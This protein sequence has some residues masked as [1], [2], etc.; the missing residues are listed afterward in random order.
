MKKK[1]K[2]LLLSVVLLSLTLGA[3][4]KA[5]PEATA[6][7][8]DAQ[9]VFTAA[10]LTANAQFTELAANTSTSEPSATP[11]LTPTATITTTT[12]T[13]AAT[14]T[15]TYPTGDS[16]LIDRVEFV[17]DINVPD[18]TVFAPNQPF[19][20]TWQLKNIGTSTWTPAYT[21]IFHGGEQMDSNPS[22]PLDKIVKPGETLDLSV[23]LIS[24]IIPGQHSSYWILRNSFG[25]NFGV[26]SNADQP[27]Y[28]IIN[29]ASNGTVMVSPTLSIPTASMTP[30]TPLP[31]GSYIK[32]VTLAVETPQYSGTCPAQMRVVATVNM[33]VKSTI[34]LELKVIVDTSGVSMQ[35]PDPYVKELDIGES[36][37]GWKMGF[38]DSWSGRMF[39]QIT[40]PENVVSDP[41]EVTIQ[42]T[43]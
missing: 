12:S 43:Q 18:Y 19:I 39:V 22:V 33:N 9:A 41:V 13:P 2:N 4:K 30:G 21:V 29:V 16:S 25:K 3:C 36:K 15:M 23:R 35:M 24:P 20:K 28:V 40:S 31:P 5:E 8:V 38:N 1:F 17:K 27:F 10:A 32:S 34:T 26:G 11:S 6:T 42:C 7:Q 14:E 37:L